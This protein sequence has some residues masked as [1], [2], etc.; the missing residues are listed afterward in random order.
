MPRVK[1]MNKANSAR[2]QSTSKPLQQFV[3][4]LELLETS[5]RVKED[6]STLLLASQKN[7]SKFPTATARAETNKSK[8]SRSAGKN[9]RKQQFDEGG[10][11]DEEPSI[12]EESDSSDSKDWPDDLP[13]L[14][15][16]DKYNSG[17]FNQNYS[18]GLR[19]KSPIHGNGNKKRR[20]KQSGR[21]TGKQ[22]GRPP[23]RQR[24]SKELSIESDES[25]E[26]ATYNGESLDDGE[27]LDI[28]DFAHA[29]PSIRTTRASN[30]QK[31]T[32]VQAKDVAH[33]QTS[34]TDGK[35]A[36]SSYE[37]E[38]LVAE[39]LMSNKER[40]SQ[41]SD[42]ADQAA[43]S[44]QPMSLEADAA[45]AMDINS[46]MAACD[47]HAS[48]ATWNRSRNQMVP[49][50]KQHRTSSLESNDSTNIN[51]SQKAKRSCKKPKRA[52]KQSH[53]L[54]NAAKNGMKRSR[55]KER[56]SKPAKLAAKEREQTSQSPVIADANAMDG[57]CNDHNDDDFDEDV[58]DSTKPSEPQHNSPSA[59]GTNDIDADM[60][61]DILTKYA[62]KTKRT[63]R[64]ADGIASKVNTD[65]F[66]QE[67][68]LGGKTTM[69]TKIHDGKDSARGSGLDCDDFTIEEVPQ[70]PPN[71]EAPTCNDD[72]SCSKTKNVDC[73]RRIFEYDELSALGTRVSPSTSASQ[74]AMA[75]E[76]GTKGK[77]F[78]RDLFEG[79]VMGT[80]DSSS[81][82]D[83]NSDFDEKVA[84]PPAT[85]TTGA[86][87]ITEDSDDN[88]TVH[89]TFVM[90]LDESRYNA[91]HSTSPAAS[92]TRD[93][94]SKTGN[95]TRKTPIEKLTGHGRNMHGE[96]TNNVRPLH[97]ETEP[98]NVSEFDTPS[99]E[100]VEIKAS[101]HKLVDGSDRGSAKDAIFHIVDANSVEASKLDPTASSNNSVKGMVN[102]DTP[103]AMRASIQDTPITQA[104][105]HQ[106]FSM[107]LFRH[108]PAFLRKQPLPTNLI[109]VYDE[110]RGLGKFQ[111]RP[112]VGGVSTLIEDASFRN[113]DG[114][115]YKAKFGGEYHFILKTVI[116]LADK[117]EQETATTGVP[118]RLLL[119]AL[120]GERRKKSTSHDPFAW[121]FV[122]QYV[123]LGGNAKRKSSQQL[124]RR[125]KRSVLP[126]TLRQTIDVARKSTSVHRR[127][128]KIVPPKPFIPTTS[129]PAASLYVEETAFLYHDPP[130]DISLPPMTPPPPRPVIPPSLSSHWWYEDDNPRV[131]RANFKGLRPIPR[132]DEDFLKLVMQC[133]QIAVV[134]DGLLEDHLSK[135][136]I[137][138]AHENVVSEIGKI[139]EVGLYHKF[140]HFVKKASESHIYDE[141]DGYIC[142]TTADYVKY[143]KLRETADR[144][145]VAKQF[146]Y[147]CGCET[148]LDDVDNEGVCPGHDII[149]V[150]TEAIYMTDVELPTFVHRL[151]GGFH[152]FFKMPQI[153]PGGRWC[154]MNAMRPTARPFMGPNLYI[155]PPGGF[156]H[157][158][159]DGHGSVD[160]GHLCID[161]YNEVFIMRRLPEQYK[162]NAVDIL[163][164]TL[165]SNYSPLYSLPHND[166][167]EKPPW[168]TT[169]TIKAFEDMNLAPIC[170]TLMPGQ[171][172]H[173][174]KGRLHAFRK[175]TRDLLPP[176]DCHFELRKKNDANFGRSARSN[177]HEH[178][179]GLE[180]FWKRQCRNKPRGCQHGRG[181]ST[182]SSEKDT[183]A[184]TDWPCCF[185]HGFVH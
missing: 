92:M 29:A 181:F 45:D 176:T 167:N 124:Q 117:L 130:N 160:S 128:G 91:R 175:A 150:R 112:V 122:K 145:G 90:D 49:V 25:R 180:L 113:C 55:S 157:I 27:S 53:L 105:H 4:V 121:T 59:F 33:S 101:S 161:G 102:S 135:D 184:G 159:Q 39:S 110:F 16:N 179:L 36:S 168:M 34:M 185:G 94:T 108:I 115:Q 120:D 137:I 37:E 5:E 104:L 65:F 183:S 109:D 76:A 138:W 14:S 95:C 88:D 125:P 73:N 72:K 97:P 103:G 126:S 82:A 40:S 163:N 166:K 86:T 43:T 158:H 18:S 84:S 178:C 140:R 162:A 64:G 69:V 170:L 156:T 118:V 153:L 132:E 41:E 31:L 2:S 169:E 47:K 66:N 77:R 56:K 171:H 32:K 147:F 8:Q 70:C 83:A 38:A 96:T 129:L 50:M 52:G 98:L 87:P 11:D 67:S 3:S 71:F 35:S 60:V 151:S 54:E 12:F 173:L 6:N 79:S 116:R 143:L 23:K 144:D 141:R 57:K 15:I 164:K 106:T 111:N 9:L 44:K 100:H 22:V 134:S 26:A 146:N 93:F 81:E 182:V 136:P 123:G 21:R 107:D 127:K 177:M 24:I 10:D 20:A 46:D 48:A 165:G 148:C 149:D 155:S 61:A 142:M 174:S 51:G 19:K 172:I 74:K 75:T 68:R 119:D 1:S 99:D 42:T 152:K 78:T 131:L 89:R 63:A 62:A 114:R 154:I 80:L 17:V 58:I 139:G 7:S 28:D 133:D 30:P 85:S 13:K